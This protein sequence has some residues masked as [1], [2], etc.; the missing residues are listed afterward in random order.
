M[1]CE[2][3]S[4]V[5]KIKIVTC[6]LL[7]RSFGNAKCIC[8]T[9]TLNKDDDDHDNEF[10]ME[11]FIEKKDAFLFALNSFV[12]I[13]RINFVLEKLKHWKALTQ[14]VGLASSKLNSTTKEVKEIV[15]TPFILVYIRRMLENPSTFF[16]LFLLLGCKYKVCWLSSGLYHLG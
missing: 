4:I 8:S 5:F 15:N 14:K 6:L 3:K 2:I 13:F 11:R 1:S 10:F 7:C 12:I 9:H 16:F